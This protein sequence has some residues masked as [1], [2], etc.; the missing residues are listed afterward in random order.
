MAQLPLPVPD[1][2]VVAG[3]VVGVGTASAG[4]LAS[5]AQRQDYRAIQRDRN[6]GRSTEATSEAR[7]APS[8]TPL[9]FPRSDEARRLG[10]RISAAPRNLAASSRIL[11]AARQ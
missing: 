9:E 8:S 6:A 11:S 1:P 5:D 3:V 10:E 4:Y 2:R 7:P